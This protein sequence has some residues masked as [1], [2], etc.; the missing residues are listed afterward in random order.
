MLQTDD[1]L[2][3]VSHEE[4]NAIQDTLHLFTVKEI[5]IEGNRQTQ[6]ATIFRE[7]SFFEGEKYSLPEL[8]KKFAAAK[9]Q[10]TNTALFHEVI[11]SLKNLQGYDAYVRIEV[12]ERWYIF[13]LPFVRTVDRSFGEWVKVQHMSMDRVNYGIRIAHYNTTG[14]NDKLNLYFMNGYTKQLALSYRNLILDR[15]QQWLA[16]A[17]FAVGKNRQ[18]DYQTAGNKRLFYKNDQQFVHSFSRSFVEVSYRQALKTKH[19]FGIGYNAESY[20]DT[21]LK[22]N[23]EFLSNQKRKFSYP[24]IYYTLS[25]FN[26]DYIPYPTK[27]YAAEVSLR[28]KGFN[29]QMNLWQMTG[30]ASASWALNHQYFLNL[31]LAGSVKLPFKQPYINQ[32]LLGFNEFYM[33]GYEY[34]VINGVAGGYTKLILARKLLNTTIHIPSSQ[35]KKLNN[36]PLRIYGKIYGNAGYAYNQLPGNNPLCNKM[37]YSTGLG[38]DIVTTYDFIIRLEWSFNQLG[39]NDLY[40]HRKNYF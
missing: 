38:L 16:S 39:Q 34:F 23:P 27:G 14:R 13:P 6:P 31:R 3:P 28:K 35:I 24:E 12:K 2:L 4:H 10:L 21:V 26:V 8:V 9:Q 22:I 7:L 20:P 5:V 29:Q 15:D 19:T 1:K 11:V 25:Y 33:Q 36:I 17:G 32:Q 37:L 40:L 30:K 18:L